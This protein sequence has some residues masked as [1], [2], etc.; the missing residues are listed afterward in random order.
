MDKRNHF[1]LDTKEKTAEDIA[2]DAIDNPD[3]LPEIL[4]GITSK[5][6]QVKFKSAK[7]LSLLGEKSP[8]KLYPH[9][10]FFITL[11]DNDNNILKWNAQDVIA[12]LTSVDTERKFDQIFEKFYGALNEGSLVTA[13]HVV[14][15]SGKIA[16]AKPAFEDRITSHLLK[17]EEAPVPTPECTEILVGKSLIAFDEYFDQIRDK[18]GVIS[19]AKK[20]LKGSRK[21]TR[22]KA[23]KFLKKH[24]PLKPI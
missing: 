24:N 12:N 15:N 9:F 7:A 11:L 13:A 22:T 16:R 17:I 3:L 20:Q 8:Q 5:N 18:S 14:E 19:F 23:E 21:A 6:S 10:D 2:Q 4:E 1:E